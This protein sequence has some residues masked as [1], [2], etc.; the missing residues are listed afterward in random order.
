MAHT[1]G[2]KDYK[3][4]YQKLTNK[5]NTII[6]LTIKMLHLISFIFLKKKEV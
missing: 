4:I 5:I 2:L 6:L 3:L 1:I